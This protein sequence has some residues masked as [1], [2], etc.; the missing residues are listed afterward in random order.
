VS[1][2]CG[3]GID[4]QDVYDDLAGIKEV[5]QELGVTVHAVKRWIERR[6][7]TDCPM[8]IKK[9][10]GINLYSLVE[11][12]GWHALWKVTR[13]AGWKGPL[14]PGVKATPENSP[15]KFPAQTG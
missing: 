13:N 2:E 1:C 4:L 3:K 11:W 14:P 9:L 5:A 6:E 7:N 15:H 10:Q 12:R 8:P